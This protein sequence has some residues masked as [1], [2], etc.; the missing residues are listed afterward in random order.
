[1]CLLIKFIQITFRI[2]NLES[3][4]TISYIFSVFTRSTYWLQSWVTINR[5][6]IIF[7]PVS[8]NLNNPRLA[9]GISIVSLICLFALHIHEMICVTNLNT[10]FLS[11]YNRVSTLIHYLVPFCIQVIGITL[12]I[13]FA[14]RSRTKITGGKMTYHQVLIKQFSHSV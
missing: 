10:H 14:A 2:T 13:I 1:M 3:C 9:V 11:T 7:F 4:K 8:T 5:L 12:L 6:L